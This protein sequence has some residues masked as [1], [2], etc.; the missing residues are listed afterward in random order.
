MLVHVHAEKNIVVDDKE[1]LTVKPGEKS[2]RIR[3]FHRISGLMLLA[4]ALTLAGCTGTIN[5]TFDI[6][7]IQSY[8]DIP[9]VT[10]EEI[11][12]IEALKV[13]REKFIF[14]QIET[15]EAFI[16]PDGTYAGFAPKVCGL[17]SRL[18]GFDFSLELL[19]WDALNKGIDGNQ[20]DFTG[21]LTPT[22]E[23][24]RR[25]FMTYPIAERSIRIFQNVDS[26]EILTEKDV[27][28]L[29]VGSLI[30]AINVDHVRQYYP[31]LT[32]SVVDV[33][34][35]A[36]AA[37]MLKSGEID[38]FISEGIIDPRFD[39]YDFIKS[40][41]FFPLVFNHVS[42]T[43]ANQDLKPV[44]DVVNKYISAGGIGTL[45]DYYRA[46]ENEYAR[47]KLGKSFTDEENAWLNSMAV[48]NASVKIAL[49]QDNYPVSFYNK[50]D[51]EYQGVALDVLSK[52]SE[53]TGIT[54]ET[55]NDKNATWSEIFEM[56]RTGEAAMVTQLLHSDERKGSFLWTDAP[57]ASAYYALLS[58]ADYPNLASYQ[59]AMAKV[60]I[61][62]GA[63]YEDKYNEWFPNSE[64][65]VL[66]DNQVDLLDALE[67]GDIDLLMGSNYLLL[68]QQN[69]REKPGYKINIRF[70]LLADSFFGFNKNE[71]ILRAIINKA[72]AY[73]NTDAISEDWTNRG[74]D[75][76]KKMAQQRSLF[77]L[78]ISIV[79]AIVLIMS[80]FFLARHKKINTRLDKIVNEMT[81]DLRASVSQLN[82][83]IANYSGV[84]WSVDNNNIITLFKGLY[85][86]EI[87]VTPDFLEGKNLD[88]ARQRNRHMDIV[89][90]VRETLEDGL[91]RDWVSEIDGKM[92]R[93]RITTI[94]GVDGKVIGVVGNT[95]EITETIKLQQ[96]LVIAVGKAE[97]AVQA[98]KSAQ[99]TVSAMFESNPHMNI[100]FDENFKLVDCNPAAY[101]FLGFKTKEDMQSGFIERMAQCIPEFQSDG[102]K[103][104]SLSEKLITAAKEGDATFE[105]ELIIDGDTRI[106]S[107]EFKR[108][109]YEESYAIVAYVFDVTEIREREMELIQRD[110]QL[111]EAVEEARAA[112]RAKSAFL[113][114]MSHEIR[115]PMNAILGITEIQ[116]QNDSL[117]PGLR[118]ALGKTYNSGT[119][120]LGIINDILD[121][122]KIEAGK[123][124]LV[125]TDYRFASLIN[126]TAQVN[127]MRIG[128]KP[129]EF[130][131]HIDENIPSALVGDEL[132]IKQ[133]LNN[134]LSNAFKYTEKGL[135]TLSVSTKAII[136][137]GNDVTLVFSVKDTG[138]GMTG[139]QVS[140]L[141][142]EYSRFNV[143]ANRTTEGT[144]LGMS[145]T[146][147]LV[148]MMNG[149]I[150]VE[151]DP[152]KGSVFTVRIPQGDTGAGPL[153]KEMAENLQQFQ[154][155]NKDYEKKK[156][157]SREFMPYGSV[158]VVDD[159]ETNI[160]VAKGLLTPYGLRIDSA[161]SGFSAI[162]K[163]KDGN[164]YDVVFMDHMMPKMDGMEA[165]KII[166]EMGYKGTIVALTA[167]AVVGQSEIFLHSGFDDFIS[168]PIDSNQLNNILNRFI[169]DRQTPEVIEAARRQAEEIKK[170]NTGKEHPV[171]P[172]IDADIA[173]I[174]TRDAIK[175]LAAL[176][177]IFARRDSF[178]EEDIRIFIINIHGIK[179]ALA[180]IGRTDLSAAAR[181]LELAGRD[182]NTEV[183]SA[184]T[185]AFLDLLRALITELAPNKEKTG[186]E[187]ADDD[188]PFLLERLKALKEA[189]AAYDKKAAR[190]MMADL[191]EKTWSR[192]TMEFLD[193]IAKYLLHSEF[194]EIVSSV[195]RFSRL[196]PAFDGTSD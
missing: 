151:S 25:F 106:L 162:D 156:H 177:E 50:T 24:M 113:S 150:L 80:L 114:N 65:T 69:Y 112:N 195:D 21:D 160:Y 4:L 16:L 89:D 30:G 41:E 37:Q 7:S 196:L 163:I 92:F 51:K 116:L 170:Q 74:Y 85:L 55:V 35:I 171:T 11:A 131:L 188:L 70:S 49:E 154:A 158:M 146:R 39:R 76:N 142:D 174:F 176:D 31:N 54:F 97:A 137:N 175:V 193:A 28:G 105:T 18:F 48:R 23:R 184:K 20:I 61:I 44:I 133:I 71:T 56:L 117:E 84:I 185:P 134:L 77:F 36:S 38:V 53:L 93:S 79:L 17:L 29:K 121:L 8:K 157:I 34:S 144:G 46:G 149:E 94:N 173:K 183:M 115:T 191:K 57:Y 78:G 145:I 103:S 179:S 192:P 165:T 155:N 3:I 62:K 72:Q 26:A 98:M 27:N 83:V 33:D 148:R 143:E 1:K 140:R 32:F 102:R 5:N 96:E 153:G 172:A 136:G 107:V 132:R 190:G 45:A 43:T 164:V 152:G 135:V 104:A 87:G 99:I 81:L 66:Y 187:A 167:N 189:G 178:S 120:L 86:N 110:Q 127:I 67:N 138:Q 82:A 52:I 118:E 182:G 15:T 180:N 129:I 108:I 122:S 124:E 100:L 12:A 73:V 123:L 109:P 181:E 194:D 88:V 130:K 101:G 168:K 68:A 14:G 119:L 141:F 42:L 63:A 161:D 166:R 2:G 169:R 159:V 60:G 13:G 40:K 75:Y 9:G 186:G 91:S 126:D 128:S 147:N 90:V 111:L 64:N 59:V 125:I 139:E 47:N 22:A 10:E 58:K 95:D 19:N 6:N